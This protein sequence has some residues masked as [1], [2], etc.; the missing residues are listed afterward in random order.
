MPGANPTGEKRRVTLPDASGRGVAGDPPGDLVDED[1]D[2]P[3]GPGLPAFVRGIPGLAWLFLGAA[4]LVAVLRLDADGMLVP[5]RQWSLD[6]GIGVVSTAGT[7]LLVLC[8]VALLHRRPAAWTE[9]RMLT[10][11]AIVVAADPIVSVVTRLVDSSL[12]S[13]L[14]TSDWFEAGVD[15]WQPASVLLALPGWLVAIAG[16]LLIVR[17]FDRLDDRPPARFPRTRVV[18]GIVMAM[19][20]ILGTQ[21]VGLILVVSTGG[22]TSIGWLNAA[23]E[24]PW[25]ALAAAWTWAALAALA[26]GRAGRG[27]WW[28]LLL[29]R[30]VLAALLPTFLLGLVFV[31][32]ALS[33][34]ND[35]GLGVMPAYWRLYALAIA[36]GVVALAGAFASVPR[37]PIVIGSAPGS[38]VHDGSGAGARCVAPD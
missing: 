1:E 17:G 32:G 18:L 21:A 26:S 4:A 23:F 29:A 3:P 8:P 27:R 20:L 38:I 24:V 34:E 16:P 19:L 10:V 30:A 36:A 37:A 6:D 2:I 15:L 31:V 7:V 25:L 14:T 33:F 12:F 5:D 28:H 22:E 11:A 35:M 13:W 9:D